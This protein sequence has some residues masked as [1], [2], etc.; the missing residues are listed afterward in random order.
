MLAVTH[1][2]QVTLS[3]THAAAMNQMTRNLACEWADD[4]IRVNAIAPWFIHTPM[5]EQALANKDFLDNIISRTPQKRVGSVDEISGAPLH[6]CLPCAG[7]AIMP[8][9]LATTCIV[10]LRKHCC[11]LS[12]DKRCVIVTCICECASAVCSLRWKCTLQRAC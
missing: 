9:L 11:R 1:T 12:A 7:S 4:G 2:I 8:G 6:Q 10:C 3:S 5:A